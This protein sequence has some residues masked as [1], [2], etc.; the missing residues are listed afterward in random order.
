MKVMLIEDDEGKAKAITSHLKKKGIPSSDV[1]RA[2][3]MTDFAGSLGA[4]IGLFIIDFKLPSVDNGIASQ[5]GKAILEAIIKAGKSNSLLLAISSYPN[6]FPELREFYESR[7]C[8]LADYSNKKGWQAT[9]DSI[10]IQLKRNVNFDF[11][12]FCALQEERNPY[13]ALL[14]GRQVTRADIDCLDVS[15]GTRKGTVVLM[16]NMG[17]VNAAVTAALCIDRF[18]PAVVGMSGICGGFSNRAA[19]GQLFVSSMAY[20]YQSGKWTTD[21]F[22]HEPYQVPTDPLL[23]A[24][25][26]ALVNKDNFIDELESGFRGGKRPTEQHKPDLGIFTS[27]SAVIADKQYLEQIQIIHRKVSALDMEVFAIQRAAELSP[28]RPKCI[29]AKTVVDLCDSEKDDDL[30]AYGSYISAKFMVKAITD[31]FS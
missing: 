19:M 5:N 24:R 25:L 21:G 11:L 12:V 26:R 9:L 30:H 16:P 20:E 13:V 18:K 6:D 8:I 15:I 23:L 3:N 29:C 4:D 10:L 17:L 31:S 28:A 1:I 7:G 2:K 14:G 22:K 27:G